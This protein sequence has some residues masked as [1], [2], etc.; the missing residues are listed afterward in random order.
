[1]PDAQGLRLAFL[2]PGQDIDVPGH[3]LNP[4][5]F[6]TKINGLNMVFKKPESLRKD[7]FTTHRPLDVSLKGEASDMDLTMG[8]ETVMLLRVVKAEACHDI[9]LDVPLQL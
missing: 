5:G 1:M 7:V 6:V 9:D 3:N 2:G 8:E 4:V